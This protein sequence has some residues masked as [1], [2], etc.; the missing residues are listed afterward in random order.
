VPGHRAG[1]QLF[2]AL[3]STP[4]ASNVRA[5][6]RRRANVP[7][8]YVSPL[9]ESS[10]VG[11]R[12]AAAP[13]AHAVLLEDRP[14]VDVV[15]EPVREPVREFARDL[16]T[17]SIERVLNSLEPVDQTT[18]FE[19]EP[20][21]RLPMLRA[22]PPT[23]AGKRR[24]VKHAGGRGP[25]FKG[26][27]SAPVLMGIAALAVSVGGV[28]TVNDAQPTSGS[29]AGDVTHSASAL[30]GTSGTGKVSTRKNGVTRDHDRAA[31][32]NAA[33]EEKLQAAADAA[34]EVRAGALTAL[35]A[36]AEVQAK[37]IAK[38]LWQYPLEPVYLTARFGQYGLWSSY[39]T[40][41]DFNGNTGDQIHSIANGEV[42]SASYDGSYGN[43]TVVR[44]EDGTELWYCHQTSF[45]VSVG[46][47]VTAGEVIGTVGS[48]GHVTGSH[49]HV[50]VHPGGG[51]AV[52]PYTAMQQHGLF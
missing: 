25:L 28:V 19:H 52:D 39:H 32:A 21:T 40:G 16:D 46:D 45:L 3:S 13:Q 1:P 41:L 4:D 50:E 44:L 48:T 17:V 49:L 43:K 42:I 24:A 20:T 15:P 29:N 33:G 34:A 47:T 2:E 7:V 22:E 10:Y 26:F 12:R 23:T 30:G 36:K 27:V 51:D 37:V 14:P 11:R 6:G 35:A 8:D 31:E 5:G 18:S 9:D 38:N